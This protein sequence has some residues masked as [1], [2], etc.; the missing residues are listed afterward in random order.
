M[1]S[2]TMLSSADVP[3]SEDGQ[4]CGA[5][6]DILPP[7]VIKTVFEISSQ[8]PAVEPVKVSEREEFEMFTVVEPGKVSECEERE[9]RDFLDEFFES[10]SSSDCDSDGGDEPVLLSDEL[11]AYYAASDIEDEDEDDI[12]ID[13]GVVIDDE[14]DFDFNLDA[15]FEGIGSEVGEEEEQKFNLSGSK[16]KLSEIEVIDLT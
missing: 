10:D 8:F 1:F 4:E 14:V 15:L 7:D 5:V 13:S 16:R 12:S 2:Q 3:L 9:M 6:E 11:P